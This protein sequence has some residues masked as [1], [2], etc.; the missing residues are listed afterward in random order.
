MGI[1][2][3]IVAEGHTGSRLAPLWRMLKLMFPEALF[4]TTRN[5]ARLARKFAGTNTEA[6]VRNSELLE[7]FRL[8]VKY[9]NTRAQMVHNRVPLSG[10]EI[11]AIR[12]RSLFLV[13][14]RDRIVNLPGARLAMEDFDLNYRIVAGAGH[15]L[16]HELPDEI[17]RDIKEFLSRDL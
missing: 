14:D 3:Y 5:A 6:L 11:G 9:Y 16:N 10:D 15:T 2:G 8:I 17:N 1:G 4:P 13:G 7:Q 12:D